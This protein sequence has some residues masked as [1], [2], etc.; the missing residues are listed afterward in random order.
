[1]CSKETDFLLANT[2]V[3]FGVSIRSIAVIYGVHK[4]KLNKQ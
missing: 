3:S 2:Q 4:K 1:M